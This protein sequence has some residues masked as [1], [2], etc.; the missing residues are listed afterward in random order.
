MVKSKTQTTETHAE[1]FRA[2][3]ALAITIA[4][5]VAYLGASFNGR[6]R[7]NGCGRY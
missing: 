7:V 2:G 6:G 5:G 4:P 1:L 3:R